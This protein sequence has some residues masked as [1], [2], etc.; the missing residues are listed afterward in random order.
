MYDYYCKTKVV[1]DIVHNT[2]YKNSIFV[3]QFRFTDKNKNV[4]L[5]DSET[6]RFVERTT[7]Y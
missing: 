4:L 2:I 6:F 3:R 1:R 7:V 5:F